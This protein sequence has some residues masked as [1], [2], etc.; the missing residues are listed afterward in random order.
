VAAVRKARTFR[1]RRGTNETHKDVHVL[2]LS[3][4]AVDRRLEREQRR[5]DVDHSRPL[6]AHDRAPGAP[7]VGGLRA[8]GECPGRDLMSAAAEATA[9]LESGAAVCSPAEPRIG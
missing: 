9:G 5:D 8:A 4:A 6:W 2:E 3:C 1:P 7:G